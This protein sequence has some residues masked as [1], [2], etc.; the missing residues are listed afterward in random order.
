[1]TNLPIKQNPSIYI[2][3]AG[4]AG[5]AIAKEISSKEIF[6]K[7]SAFLD[8]DPKK[9]GTK[10]DGVPVLGSISEAVRLIRIDSGAEALIAIP[11]ISSERLREIFG[12]LKNAG[13]SRIKLL[14]AISQII[15]GSAHLVQA[16]D[17]DPQDLLSRTPVKISLKKSLA[18]LRGKRVLITGA[19]G[20]IGSELARQLLSGGAERLYLFGHGENSIYQIHKELKLLQSGGVGDKATIVP[21]I[22]ELKDRNYMRYIINRLKCDAVFHTAAYKHVPLME[23]N[24]VAV[25]ENN[26][27]GT[28]N[29]LD[30]CLEFGVKKFVLIST[31]KAVE[32]VSVYGLSKMLNEKSVLQAAEKAKN[33]NENSAYMFVRFGNVLGSR[34]SIFPLFVEQIKTG[35]PV[36]VTDKKMTRYFMT[37][38]E[39]C[40]L[41]LQT[42]GVG[43]SGQSYLLDMGE[44]VNIFETAKQLIRYM[45]FEPEKDIKIEIIGV[46]EG[47]RLEEPLWSK[48]EYLEKT[49]YE[50]IMLLKDSVPFDSDRLNYLLEKL[51]PF[52]FYTE[53]K[54]DLFR[55][56]DKMKNFIRNE[57]LVL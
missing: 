20:S 30:A 36:T 51:A 38:P 46:R 55:N 56:K 14:P 48:S 27:F 11:S 33:S 3:G 25:I 34:G 52:C 40:S 35:G 7:V 13:F 16:R 22:G 57:G 54:E 24:P 5:T 45:G 50:K 43:K 15:D 6:G 41:V 1:M 29:L 42:G 37:I 44:P 10:I 12:I 18:Y 21:I 47:E 17:I 23:E 28:K 32:P 8:D 19:G 9:I 2:V 26:V 53:G 31:D 49:D 39:A 4:F